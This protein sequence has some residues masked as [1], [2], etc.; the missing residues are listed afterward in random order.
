MNPNNANEYFP[1]FTS[2][3]NQRMIDDLT[4][5]ILTAEDTAELVK[6]LI[7]AMPYDTR[8]AILAELMH[9]R[10]LR[11]ELLGVA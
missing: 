3:F 5:D 11:P 7:E 8:Q 1:H 6:N 4:E 2:W 10:V 9:S